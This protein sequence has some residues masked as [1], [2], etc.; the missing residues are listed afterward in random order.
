M[1][2]PSGIPDRECCIGPRTGSPIRVLHVT[3]AMTKGGGVAVWLMNVLGGIDTNRFRLDLL[4]DTNVECELDAE[5]RSLGCRIMYCP[6]GVKDPW[7]FRRRFNATVT[8]HGPYDIV[9]SHRDN[10]DGLVLTWAA[11]LGIPVRISH[12][13]ND[14]RNVERSLP[15]VKRHYARFKRKMLHRSMTFG[16]ACSTDAAACQFGAGWKDDP[17]I[18]LLRY[19]IDLVPFRE[20]VDRATVRGSFGIRED[21]FVIGHVGR[22]VDQKNHEMLIHIMRKVVDQD[23]SAHLLLVGRGPLQHDIFNLTQS[24]ELTE[25]IHFAGLRPDIARL[26]R[27]AMDVFVF[28]SKHEGLGIVMLEAQA[29]GIPVVASTAVPKDATVIPELVKRCSVSDPPTVWANAIMRVKGQR[30]VDNTACIAEV[31]KE[32]DAA[33]AAALIEKVYLQCLPMVEVP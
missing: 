6:D 13:H 9:H 11:E 10:I 5:V 17:R 33:N 14:L 23:P 27:G 26:M 29:A 21:A 24:L 16:L 4:V 28:P 18:A 3:G 1:R 8:A 19:G 2:I 7:G 22:F 20:P 15:L 31:S 30:K 25:H 12:S 32:H